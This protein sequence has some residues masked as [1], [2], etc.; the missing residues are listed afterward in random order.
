MSKQRRSNC[1]YCGASG[2]DV[3]I[4]LRGICDSCAAD[5]VTMNNTSIAT[6][7]GE[8]YARWAEATAL[9]IAKRL[10]AIQALHRPPTQ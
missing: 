5:R 4:S 2:N 7:E 8:A 1:R 6:G 10:E 3:P 9:G